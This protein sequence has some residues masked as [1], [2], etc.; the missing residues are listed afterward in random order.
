MATSK[1]D[2]PGGNSLRYEA[3]FLIWFPAS[4]L[5]LVFEGSKTL[6]LNTTRKERNNS[7]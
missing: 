4:H 3:H 6:D 7:R 5:D 2:Q 1:E